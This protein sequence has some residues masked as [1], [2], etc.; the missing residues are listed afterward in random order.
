MHLH[1]APQ[2]FALSRTS[3]PVI[4]GYTVTFSGVFH[5]GA[6][7]RIRVQSADF[8]LTVTMATATTFVYVLLC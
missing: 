4:G 8:T 5:Q 3:G 7:Q 1:L 2:L 6:A